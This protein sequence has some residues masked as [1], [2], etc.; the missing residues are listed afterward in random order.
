MLFKGSKCCW[1]WIDANRKGSVLMALLSRLVEVRWY[2]LFEWSEGFPGLLEAGLHVEQG[3]GIAVGDTVAF[4]D[5]VG[6][7][8]ELFVLQVAEVGDAAAPVVLVD[9]LPVLC[10]DADNIFVVEEDDCVVR[11]RGSSGEHVGDVA[12]VE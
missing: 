12:A 3:V 1:I 9:V 11:G 8:E 10:S 6:R 5:V 7:I 2:A 4:R